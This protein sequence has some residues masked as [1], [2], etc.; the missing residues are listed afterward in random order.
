[1][2][3]E[4]YYKSFGF[5]SYPFGVFTTEAETDVFKDTYLMPPN[6]TVIL[7][8]LRNTSAIVIGERGTGKTALA[9]DLGNELGNAKNIVV[10][11][12][13][14]SSLKT[15]Y[16]V[17]D[18]YKFLIE[19]ITASFFSYF[20]DN[21]RALWKCT[22]E[23][24]FDLSM[25]LNKYMGSTTKTILRDKIGRIQ[26]GLIK[27]TSIKLYNFSRVAFNYGLKAATKTISDALTKHFS[28]L[29][30]F[31]AGDAE[32]FK[33]YEMEIDDKFTIDQK[34]FFYLEK[35][36]KIIKNTGIE[37]IYVIVDK[38]DEDPRFENDAEDIS[39]YIKLLASN[40][41]IL[42]N[43]LFHILLFMWST[44]FNYIKDN[45]RTQKLSFTSLEWDNTDLKNVLERRISSYSKKAL[46]NA[47]DIFE[48][49]G[50]KNIDLIFDMCNRNPRD[51]WHILNKAFQEQ[52][53]VDNSK[54]ITD[55]A[56]ESAIK[57]F[58]L[59]FNYYEYYPR[60]S[61]ARS[62]SMD[63]YR[64]IKHLLKLD[65][66]RFTKDKLNTMAGTGSSTNNYVVAM[67]NMGL[68]RNSGDKVQGQGGAVIYQIL[69]P[70][71]RYAMQQGISIGE[72]E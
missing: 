71:V 9:K 60:K 53:A 21:P 49:S 24:R 59:E 47:T 31:D 43:D 70:K 29:P 13:E 51:M 8:G 38:I 10:R 63:I 50:A 34:Q 20:A 16:N 41:K 68:L 17:E 18:L 11:I 1:M 65:C 62:N 14:F 5:L 27:R 4:Q 46:Q 7:E 40:N 23:E 12:E 3:F 42:T 28:A 33:R 58:V 36:C 55:K 39:E 44:P 15:K 30:E 32:Y 67:E 37:K 25:F 64:Y 35:L 61:S 2:T 52:F 19:K 66:D 56:I 48:P 22:K 54:K 45:V 57:R 26:N 69:D 72:K 6:R